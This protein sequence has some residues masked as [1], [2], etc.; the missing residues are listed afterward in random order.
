M[1]D[2]NGQT[3][4]IPVGATSKITQLRTAP[5]RCAPGHFG[6]LHK[7]PER[8]HTWSSASAHRLL[9]DLKFCSSASTHGI[10]FGLKFRLRTRNILRLKVPQFRFRIQNSVWLGALKW[11]NAASA[12]EK[13]CGLEVTQ[14][15]FHTINLVRLEVSQFRFHIRALILS[16]TVPPSHKEYPV[17]WSSAVSLPHKEYTISRSWAVLLSHTEQSVTWSSSVSHN[18]LWLESLQFH[19]RKKRRHLKFRTSASAW[20]NY[21]SLENPLSF[22]HPPIS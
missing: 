16:L 13:Y 5:P 22:N 19:F 11:R 7:K 4:T 9:C 1:R 8:F 12:Q 6:L 17:T 15:C 10:F 14:F 2:K 18:M 20:E 21:F 3:K